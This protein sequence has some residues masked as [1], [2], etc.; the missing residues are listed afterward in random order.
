MRDTLNKILELY[1]DDRFLGITMFYREKV[2]HKQFG[3]FSTFAAESF[4]DGWLKAIEKGVWVEDGKYGD[5][6]RETFELQ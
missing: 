3:L 2:K 5:N 6:F 4:P 1:P